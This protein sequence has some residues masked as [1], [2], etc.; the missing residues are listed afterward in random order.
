MKIKDTLLLGIL[1]GLIGPTAGIAIF[2]MVNYL[3]T[4]FIE[5]L[6]LSFEAKFLSPLLSLS[7]IIN[8]GV[9]YLFIH[10]EHYQ[11][12]RGVIFSTILYGVAIVLLKFIW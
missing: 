9:F 3:H 7:A 1:L 10:F 12:A 2:Y 11:S 8:L 5:F 6:T 4:P